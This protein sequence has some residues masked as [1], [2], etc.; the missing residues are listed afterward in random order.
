MASGL[1]VAGTPVG[2]AAEILVEGENA[3]TFSPGDAAGLARHFSRL[4]ELPGL[5]RRLAQNGVRTAR[6][7]FDLQQMVAGIEEYLA[8]VTAK[9]SV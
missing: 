3:L 2:G 7:K 6:E 5:R 1:A 4:A 8:A 9:Q